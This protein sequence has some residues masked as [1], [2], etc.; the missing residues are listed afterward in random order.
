MIVPLLPF[1]YGFPGGSDGKASGCNVGDSGLIA[2]WGRSSGER[3]GNPLQ[4][5]CLEIPWKKQPGILQ[6]MGSQRVRH[7]WATSLTH[8]LTTISLWL[9]LWA[10]MWVSFSDGFQHPLINGC[11]TAICDFGSFKRRLSNVLLLCHLDPIS[12]IVTL[13]ARITIFSQWLMIRSDWMF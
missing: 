8:L 7:N 11:L 12:F 5:P 13:A 6:S 3:N 4:Y 9:V 2:A 1:H 10:W